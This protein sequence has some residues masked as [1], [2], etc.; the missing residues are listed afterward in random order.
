MLANQEAT[1]AKIEY[2]HAKEKKIEC[3]RYE[4]VTNGCLMNRNESFREYLGVASTGDKLR[5]VRLRW[6]EMSNASQQ[7]QHNTIEENFLYCKLMTY[8]GKGVGQRAHGWL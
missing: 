4:N 1:N 6:F 3:S 2:K 5:E 7:W 8:Q